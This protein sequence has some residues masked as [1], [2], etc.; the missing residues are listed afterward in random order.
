MIF[1][2]SGLG[3]KLKY[4]LLLLV[5]LSGMPLQGFRCDEPGRYGR[6]SDGSPVALGSTGPHAAWVKQMNPSQGPTQATELKVFKAT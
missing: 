4:P 3:I 1:N 2:Y 6:V 5:M